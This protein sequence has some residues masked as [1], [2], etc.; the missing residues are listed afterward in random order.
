[1]SQPLEAF[2]QFE[3]SIRKMV[4][5]KAK[6]LRKSAKKARKKKKRKLPAEDAREQL[7]EVF[8]LLDKH[9]DTAFSREFGEASVRV[10]LVLDG[11]VLLEQVPPRLL[12]SLRKP[13]KR[14]RKAAR[15]LVK[16]HGD[17]FEALAGRANRLEEALLAALDEANATAVDQRQASTALVNYL[18]G[19]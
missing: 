17:E 11:D 5:K 8:S 16:L 19:Q 14:V 12:V 4:K 18:R 3:K 9:V 15:E 1:M 6:G 7:D 2:V 13:V 10:D